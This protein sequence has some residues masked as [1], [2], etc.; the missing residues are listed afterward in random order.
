MTDD[1]E[2]NDTP[3]T[4]QQDYGADLAGQ[5]GGG[6]ESFIYEEPPKAQISRGTLL[7]FGLAAIAGGVIWFMYVR[8]GPQ[9]ADA[10]SLEAQD[11]DQTIT[12]FLSSGTRNIEKMQQMLR[13]TEGIVEQFRDYPAIKQVPL[14]QLQTNPF[15][16]SILNDT[17][18]PN[19]AN[20]KREEERNAAV[21]AVQQL[22]LRSIMHSGSHR[23][24]MINNTLYQEGQQVDGFTIEQITPESVIVKSGVYR[25]ELKMQ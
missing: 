4:D 22:A 25:F 20:R 2:M 13:N 18:D 1:T 16:F 3:D 5:L 9:A 6:D 17:K 21:K 23:A 15:R 12:Q 8:N 14:S 7:L 11:A 19:L 24:C 10:A